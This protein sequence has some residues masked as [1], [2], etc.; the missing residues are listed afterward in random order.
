MDK[1]VA[2]MEVMIY[3]WGESVAGVL[4]NAGHVILELDVNSCN[5][6]VS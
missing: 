3:S 1:D 2:I 6:Y 4:D 5:I